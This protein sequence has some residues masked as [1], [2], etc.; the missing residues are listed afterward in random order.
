MNN[1]NSLGNRDSFKPSDLKQEK[2]ELMLLGNINDQNNY[3][4]LVRIT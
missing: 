4:A 1:R 3:Y 2:N